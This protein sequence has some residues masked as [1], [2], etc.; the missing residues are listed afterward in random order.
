VLFSA[1]YLNRILYT[2]WRANEPELPVEISAPNESGLA[3]AYARKYDIAETLA[4]QIVQSALAEGIDPDLAFRL[5]RVESVF[6][7]TARGPM[8]ALGLTQLMPA[9]ARSIDRRLR[10]E[11]AILEPQTNL[12]TGFRY[13]KS[14]IERYDGDVRLGLLAYNRGIGSVDRALREGRDPDNGYARKVLG[15]VTDQYTGGGLVAPH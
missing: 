6:R 15:S 12:R 2:V 13:L 11:A 4:L 7:P 10:T 14:M 9:T 5:V 1:E 8:G 3:A